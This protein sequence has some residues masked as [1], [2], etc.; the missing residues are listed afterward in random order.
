MAKKQDKGRLRLWQERL[1][2]NEA[3]YQSEIDRMDEREALYA[4]TNALRPIVQGER[5]T[6]T[7]H[8]RNICAEI[9]EAQTD[10]NIPQPKVTA[11]RKQ[12]EMKAKLIEDMLRN[13]LDRMPF[14][15]LNDIMERTVPIQGG[16]AFLVEWDNTQRTHFTIGE[17]S[18]STL[19]PKQII[20]QDGVYTGIEDMDYVILKI[21]QT[22]EYIRRRY[23]VD[24]RDETE[25]EPDIK[26]SGS[27]STADDLVTQYIA[28][29]R[30]DKGGIGLYSWVND[31]QL[32]DLEDYQA[33]RLRRCAKCGAIE[34]TGADG[35]DISAEMS[36]RLTPTR[37][38]GARF[39]GG[40]RPAPT[41]AE[42]RQPVPPE[43]PSALPGGTRSADLWAGL[44]GPGDAMHWTGEE[45]IPYP[46]K[47]ERWG[48]K[49][50]PYC[51]GSRWEETE[52]GYE[53]IPVAVT[54]SDGSTVGGMI[55]REQA[56]DTVVDEMGLP[57]VEIVEEPTRV[58]FYKP[59]IF[60]V[61]LQKNVSVYGRFLGDSDID[62]IADQQNTTNRIETKII[63]K[64]LKSGSYITLPDEA[65]IRVDA[66]DMKVI[67]PGNA[68]SK[69]LIDVYDLQGNI[70]QDLTYLAQVYEEARQIIGITDSFQGRT[71]ATATSGKAKEFAAA[72]SA[73]RLESK[74]V[75]KDAAYAALFEAMFKFKLAYTDEPRPV[76]SNDIH[77]NAQYE[78]FNRYDFLEQ[79]AAGEWCWN[80]QFLFSCD[81]SAPLA[82]NREAMW[83]E[84]RMNLQTGAFGDPA[85]IQT[86]ILFWTKM[87]LLHYPGAGETRAYLEEEMRKQQIQQ[88]MAQ[89]A[90]QMQQLQQKV[91]ASG[92]DAQSAQAAIL[93]A[94][95]DAARD[96]GASAGMPG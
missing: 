36:Y 96:S 74:R 75:M 93:K 3:A 81:T 77:G 61:I 69:A 58:P 84:T 8:V 17:L 80:D 32:E 30:N 18:V 87:E 60:P 25:E 51:G 47:P 71:D 78:T 39:A 83:Q 91:Q 70:Q 66:E 46:E 1:K 35:A 12:D 76:V 88:Q 45:L 20:P 29:Y 90:Q 64:L 57:V 73:G 19:H 23:G 54:R 6:K 34:P 10:S 33:R 26:G 44:P 55:R 50:C 9:I 49:T 82:S 53:E 37:L 67:R 27:A 13:E 65:S 31:T 40:K 15:Q 89:Q 2:T 62:K 72:Q 68:A 86:L 95:Q 14:E 94:K 5:K 43:T 41:E 16:A 52:E 85:Q 7:A 22:K 79:D 42:L 92:L 24:V 48:G 28:Y 63:D 59:D 38:P 56:S 11:R 21:P 4:G